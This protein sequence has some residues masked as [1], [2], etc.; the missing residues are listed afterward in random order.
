[1]QLFAH[2]DPMHQGGTEIGSRTRPLKWSKRCRCAA[3]LHTWHKSVFRK[4]KRF[5]GSIVRPF[6]LPSDAANAKIVG[7]D[8]CLLVNTCLRMNCCR[9]A[10]WVELGWKGVE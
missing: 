10:Q 5:G 4:I 8:D 2:V 7:L 1:M 3:F 6:V 9:T